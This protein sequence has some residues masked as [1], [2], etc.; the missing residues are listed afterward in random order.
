M[1]TKY[2]YGN[3]FKR[4]FWFLEIGITINFSII[5]E[6]KKDILLKLNSLSNAISDPDLILAFFNLF[7]QNVILSKNSLLL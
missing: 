5:V 1:L 7:L 6:M 3:K 2:W 4:S